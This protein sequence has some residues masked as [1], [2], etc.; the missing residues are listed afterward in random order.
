[1]T[2]LRV[3]LL[4]ARGHGRWHL[5]NIRRLRERD[6]EL[7]GVYHPLPADV[8][9]DQLIGNVPVSDDL[10]RLLRSTAPDITVVS[11]PIH[12]H[13]PLAL[14]A[15]EHGSAVLLE[16]PPAPTMAE[17]QALVDGAN[18]V[19]CQ[20]GFQSLGSA[21]LPAVRQVIEEGSIGALRGIGAA[22]TWIREAAYFRRSPWAGHRHLDGVPVMDGA[23]SNPF[24]HAVVTALQ[25]AD[26]GRSTALADIEVDLYRA[27]DMESDD[28]SALRLTTGDGSVVTVAVTL[29]PE[30]HREPRVVVHGSRGT[31][32]LM[33]TR[34]EVTVEN[35]ERRTRRY[36]RTDLLEN[37]ADHLVDRT[38]PLVAPLASMR[39]FMQVMEAIA[40]SPD[41]TVIPRAY[42]TAQG[43]G[44]SRR[45]VVR[46]IDD[47]IERSVRDLAL[48]RELDLAWATRNPPD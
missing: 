26:A 38:V 4:G 33:Y 18:G 19:P 32:T 35:G 3:L 37:L 25:V 20:V 13:V 24:S 6:I 2:A 17:Y 14:E 30:L 47:A 21:A 9:R 42:I 48:F 16:K 15:M 46:G 40:E 28:T 44:D 10:G 43:A 12:T 39:P 41:P 27:H 22:G 34:D 11:T 7:V 23:L 36:P 5:N 45:L 31:V 29:C 1:M 8:Q